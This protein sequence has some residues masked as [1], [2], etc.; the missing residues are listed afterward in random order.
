MEPT[1]EVSSFH[2][3]KLGIAWVLGCIVSY[4]T[5]LSYVGNSDIKPPLPVVD[6]ERS[7]RSGEKTAKSWEI[8]NSNIAHRIK[9][10][11]TNIKF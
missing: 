4:I 3:M 6:P 7:Y 11:E 9:L 10:G 2:S 8:R 1:S 5:Q